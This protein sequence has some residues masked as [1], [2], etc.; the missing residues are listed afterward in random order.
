M[1][2]KESALKPVSKPVCL[3]TTQ[4]QSQC[5]LCCTKNQFASKDDC[6][7]DQVLP[8]RHQRW[9]LR[10]TSEIVRQN[11]RDDSN[12]GT[13]TLVSFEAK[14]SFAITC[15]PI[16]NLA[17]T[18]N[19]VSSCQEWLL[20]HASSLGSCSWYL[21]QQG[22][23]VRPVLDCL[24]ALYFHL[25]WAH[26]LPEAQHDKTRHL[27]RTQTNTTQFWPSA[28]WDLLGKI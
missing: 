5:E 13:G 21:V 7:T 6:T 28:L 22:P 9:V 24:V 12:P 2:A 27:H 10:T 4:Q 17:T 23:R 18:Y 19:F 25:G 26:K 15:K 16:T 3:D 14:I 11:W 1:T 20:F 8:E